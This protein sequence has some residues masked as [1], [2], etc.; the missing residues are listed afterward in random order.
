MDEQLTERSEAN[1]ENPF[2]HTQNKLMYKVALTTCNRLKLCVL[3][4]RYY[5]AENKII[6]IVM[7][8]VS[9]LI[10]GLTLEEKNFI[11]QMSN[12]DQKIVP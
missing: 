5:F 12:L 6:I 4:R 11:S 9:A 3:H 1:G 8:Q 2:L 10:K 7:T